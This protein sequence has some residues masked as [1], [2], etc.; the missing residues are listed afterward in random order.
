MKGSDFAE[1]NRQL[2]L[3]AQDQAI[4]NKYSKLSQEAS[5]KYSEDNLAQIWD[6]FYHE[7]YE[8]GRKLGQI[9]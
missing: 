9:H 5:A 2:Q 4:L 3:A 1:M 8:I 7:Q 6:D